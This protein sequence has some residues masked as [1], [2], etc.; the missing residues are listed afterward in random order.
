M[1]GIGQP[2]ISNNELILLPIDEAALLE[3]GHRA[4]VAD[5]GGICEMGAAIA[6]QITDRRCA[7]TLLRIEGDP[8][9][10]SQSPFSQKIAIR[11]GAFLV[12]NNQVGK[13][14]D[15]ACAETKKNGRV[16][17]GETLEVAINPAFPR[18]S[19]QRIT[20]MSEMIEA[21]GN[22]S[23][24]GQPLIAQLGLL[25]SQAVIR[26]VR[27]IYPPLAWQHLGQMG[28]TKQGDAAGC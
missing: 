20:R 22:I 25:K 1:P 28:I 8:A 6:Q 7:N 15:R 23:C 10:R 18:G 2:G 17:L 24:L 13:A 3:I 14:A 12:L 11:T 5:G 27:R 19:R 16:I 4:A 21:N 9:R 26:Q